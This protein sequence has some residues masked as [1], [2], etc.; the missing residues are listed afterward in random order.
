MGSLFKNRKSKTLQTDLPLQ[1]GKLNPVLLLVSHTFS[2]NIL[3][4]LKEMPKTLVSTLKT[5]S[6]ISSFDSHRKVKREVPEHP[7]VAT[8]WTEAYMFPLYLKKTWATQKCDLIRG[9]RDHRASGSSMLLSSAWAKPGR[10]AQPYW[11]SWNRGQHSARKGVEGRLCLQEDSHLFTL[12][13]H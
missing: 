8:P 5:V 9:K 12:R 3:I 10:H 13:P 2:Y 7:L 4:R 11:T 6:S 1:N